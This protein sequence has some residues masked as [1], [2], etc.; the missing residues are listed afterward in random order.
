MVLSD[1]RVNNV[2]GVDLD[3]TYKEGQQV[4]VRRKGKGPW[5]VAAITKAR[6]AEWACGA[7]PAYYDVVYDDSTQQA[8]VLLALSLMQTSLVRVGVL[9]V[10]PFI[11][12]CFQ[13]AAKEARLQCEAHCRSRVAGAVAGFDKMVNALFDDGAFEVS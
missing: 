9:Y 4:E 1:L 11:G 6:G 2:I 8:C 3:A 7:C 5:R 12:S 13:R 10:I